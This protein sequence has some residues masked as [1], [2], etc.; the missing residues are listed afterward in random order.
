MELCDFDESKILEKL[1]EQI[2]F[3]ELIFHLTK[4]SFP[5]VKQ[6]LSQFNTR[7]VQSLLFNAADLFQ[8]KAFADVF[9]THREITN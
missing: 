2:K 8:L 3:E 7:Y 4:D 5:E 9:F 6:I 1:H